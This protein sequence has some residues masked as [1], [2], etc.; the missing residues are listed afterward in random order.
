[1]E[2]L[3]F[4]PREEMSNAAS[5]FRF[6]TP[7]AEH[8]THL[9]GWVRVSVVAQITESSSVRVIERDFSLDYWKFST[10]AS[11]VCSCCST[12]STMRPSREASR[13]GFP[14]WADSSRR[15]T[16]VNLRVLKL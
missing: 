13:L 16:G 14:A 3:G 8:S 4:W 12:K 2:A 9:R 1:M 7:N 11:A 6:G 5:A 10:M 15:M